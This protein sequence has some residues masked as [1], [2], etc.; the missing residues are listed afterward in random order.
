MYQTMLI[1][2]RLLKAV[3]KKKT[4]TLKFSFQNEIK[5]NFCIGL[6]TSNFFQFL[7]IVVDNFGLTVQNSIVNI[8]D[9][10]DA[11][12]KTVEALQHVLSK[13]ADNIDLFLKVSF[14]GSSRALL[15]PQVI[16]LHK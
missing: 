12:I 9:H 14:G 8:V 6:S 10:Q 16:Y 7:F 2:L 15:T 3:S 4:N 1:L 5:F 13:C 11:K